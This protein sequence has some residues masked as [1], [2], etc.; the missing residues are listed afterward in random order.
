MTSCKTVVPAGLLALAACMPL[1]YEPTPAPESL[2][3]CHAGIVGVESR[4]LRD[5]TRGE[6]TDLILDRGWVAEDVLLVAELDEPV[7]LRNPRELALALQEAYPRELRDRG[8]GGEA[9][10]GLLVDAT[11]A[12]REVALLESSGHDALDAAGAE[13]YRTAR[14]TAAVYRGCRSLYWTAVRATF[15]A[16]PAGPVALSR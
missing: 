9:E 12:V 15:D 2:P 6:I 13:A 4:V 1:D 3:A 7:S 14:Y 16:R 5:R 11:G 10:Y 8:I